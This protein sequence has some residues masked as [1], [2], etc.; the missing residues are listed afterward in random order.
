[1]TSP[2][3]IERALLTAEKIRL[4][5]RA[6]RNRGPHQKGGKG[7]KKQERREQPHNSVFIDLRIK[8]PNIRQ[9]EILHFLDSTHI[10]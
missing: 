5:T 7:K 10:R 2:L 3:F 6:G 1:M 9:A 8:L 4:R